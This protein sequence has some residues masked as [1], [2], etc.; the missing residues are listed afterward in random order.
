MRL[1]FVLTLMFISALTPIASGEFAVRGWLVHDPDLPY[2]KACLDRAGEFGINHIQLSH[3]IIHHGHEVLVDESRRAMVEEMAAYARSKGVKNYL[4]THE[5]HRVPDSLMQDGKVDLDNPAT[6]EWLRDKYHQIFDAIPSTDGLILTFHETQYSV[7]HDSRCTSKLSPPE[8]VAKL[9]TELAA[10]CR[11]R[12]KELYV[13]TFVYQPDELAWVV[14]GIHACPP[15]V[16][17]MSKCVPHDWQPLYP[18]N[19][20]IGLFP[21]RTHIVELD[22]AGEYYGQSIVPYCH[23]EYVQMRLRYARD[24]NLQGGVARIDRYSNH[25]FGTPN[26]VNIH[27]W[28]DFLTD[29]DRDAEA[30]WSA[31]VRKMYGPAHTADLVRMLKRTWPITLKTYLTLDFYF[32]NNHSR[33]ASLS[34]AESHIRSHSIA[35]WNRD[36]APVEAEL[37]NPTPDTLRRALVEK[38]E[39]IELA[40]KN[41][42]DLARIRA[43]LPKAVGDTL[44]HHLMKSYRCAVLWRGLTEAYFTLKLY[45]QSGDAADRAHCLSAL[46]YLEQHADQLEAE[47]GPDAEYESAALTRSFLQDVRNALEQ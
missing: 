31:A 9:I 40:E 33:V 36:Y 7:Y 21:E 44:Q 16:A 45:Q 19:P 24:K 22:I 6:W 37:L 39:A 34:Y 25:A 20:A 17:V 27:A 14:E 2:V 12:G 26:E 1:R 10:V 11:E 4:W 15:D 3:R 29:P 32:L 41:L 35:K 43:G 30:V 28:S 38:V 42:A 46:A 23:P 47:V 13:R 8:R 5:M 18:H